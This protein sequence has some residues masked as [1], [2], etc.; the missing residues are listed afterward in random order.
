MKQNCCKSGSS[1]MIADPLWSCVMLLCGPLWSFAVFSHTPRVEFVPEFGCLLMTVVPYH[2]DS[3]VT[4]T[5]SNLT[6]TVSRNETRTD[7]W[8]STKVTAYLGTPK[9][10]TIKKPNRLH[11]MP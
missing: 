1:L 8:S 4:P 9:W 2:P 5:H 6:L 10:D 11:N 3:C 7:W